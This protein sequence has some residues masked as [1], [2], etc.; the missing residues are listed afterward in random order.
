MDVDVHQYAGVMDL[1]VN[2]SRMLDQFGST[3]SMPSNFVM[4]MLQP[5]GYDPDRGWKN[6]SYPK[7]NGAGSG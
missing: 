1:T 4:R 6:A 2:R 5:Q 3:C 7:K